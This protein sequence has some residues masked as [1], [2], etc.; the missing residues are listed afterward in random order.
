MHFGGGRDLTRGSILRNLLFL[1][2][3]MIVGNSVN[4]IGPTVD[5]I[6]VGRLGP[7]AIAGV[8]VSGIAVMLAQSGLMG[9]FQGLRSMVS[10]FIG[11]RDEK[12]ANHVAQQAVVIGAVSSAVL[13]IMGIFF[14]E[15]ILRLVGVEQAVIAE[16]A[17]YL[18]IQFVG[19]TAMSFR[20]MAEGIMQASGDAV[21]PMKIAVAFRLL[22]VVL[23]PLLIFGIWIFPRMGVN[24]AA[25][26]NVFS[27]SLGTALA[28]WILLKGQSRLKLS[29][30][31]FRIDPRMVWRIIRIGFPASV[32]GMQMTLGQFLLM[33]FVAPFGTLAVAAH[34][35][36]QRIEMIMFMPAWGVGMAAGVLAGQNLGAFQ[37]ARAE[38][39]GW[40]GT[41]L[42][43][44]FAILCSLAILLWAPAIVHVFSSDAELVRLA[45]TFLR[46]AVG[47]YVVTGFVGVLQQSISGAGDTLMPM[48]VSLL[49]MWLV[50]LP[51]AFF[52]S[53]NT[54]LGVY[55][56]RWAIVASSAANAIAYTT[57]FRLGKW[58]QKRV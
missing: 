42:V 16:S 54:S 27:Q 34:T 8:G 21:T 31:G 46:I 6:W 7:D 53:R 56:I 32:M 30:T 36:N 23:S 41:V 48:V 49:A 18:R 33:F 17:D 10:R 29:F 37:P 25:V 3:P 57:Y 35:L 4:M 19:M 24:G 2:W 51:L 20:M 43:E 38:K 26:T 15:G 28:F 47:G 39:S 44:A 9:L 55:G 13:A 45:S 11:A 12:Q 14:A 50:L 52:L 58:K 40:L 5:M 1:S 22:H